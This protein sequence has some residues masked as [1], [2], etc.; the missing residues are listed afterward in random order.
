VS[1]YSSTYTRAGQK[2]FNP[3]LGETYECIREDKGWKFLAEQVSH[4]P[5]VSTCH[6]ES[7]NFVFWQDMQVKT[8]FWGKS[9]E[10]EPIGVINVM[11]TRHEERYSWNKATSCVH[12]ILGGQRW[13]EHYGEV[14]IT[15]H[16]RD[17]VCK[18]TLAKSSYWS[19]NRHEVY[20]SVLNKEGKVV[21][22][23][24]GKWNE[25]I[26]FGD[27][28][29][30]KCIWRPGAM[31]PDSGIYYGFTRFAMELN[32]IDSEQTQLYP[33]TDTRFRPDQRLLEEGKLN[34]A[35]AEKHRLEQVQREMRKGREEENIVYTPKWFTKSELGKKETYKFNSQYWEVR[36][37]P[38]FAKL[39]L[40]KL[41]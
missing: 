22:H 37:N 19:T 1:G 31:P 24:F 16:T 23:L 34:D 18:L 21:H 3:L 30:A 32:E 39:D 38:G 26:Y 40:L 8:K 5:P 33:P 17:I 11:L 14:I 2:P 29:S 13:V 20:G 36:K 12:N 6:C 10:V 7:N 28:Q 4:H 9:M 27:V 35:E 15:N 41:W 25:G